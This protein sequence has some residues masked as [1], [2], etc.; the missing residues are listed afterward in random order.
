[1]QMYNGTRTSEG[2]FNVGL[3]KLFYLAGSGNKRKLVEAFPEF[4][5]GEVPEFGI[6]KKEEA[7]KTFK[8][9]GWLCG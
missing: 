2:S 1:M 3:Q 9:K 6:H 7:N 5:G 8:Y 4:F